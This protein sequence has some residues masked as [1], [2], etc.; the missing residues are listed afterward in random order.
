ML[1]VRPVAVMCACVA[2]A[3]CGQT[4][5]SQVPGTAPSAFQVTPAEIDLSPSAPADTFNGQDDVAGVS[6][7]PLASPECTGANGSIVVGGNGV[8]Q[9]DVAG[10]ALLFTVV[11]AG[12][13]PPAQC[14]ITVL[15]SDG[16]YGV[17][18]ANYSNVPVS[19]I[20]AAERRIIASP[21]SSSSTLTFTS[22]ASPQNIDVSGFTG[23]TAATVSCKSTGSGV[24]VTPAQVSG[25][26]TFAVIPFGQGAISNSCG[27][28]IADQS[29]HHVTVTATLSISAVAKFTAT[30]DK[31]QFGCAGTAAPL[32]CRTLTPIALSEPGTPAFSI[33]TRPTLKGSCAN[34]FYGPLAM[35][36]GPAATLF[37]GLLPV[38]TLACSAV[39]VTDGSTPAQ[40]VRIAIAPA[41]A[42]APAG[43]AAATAP[44]CTGS[45]ARVAAPR[46][47][48][49]MYVWNPYKVDGGVYESYLES[50]VI[51]KD[52]ALCGVS[53]LVSW[54]EIEKTKG[55]YTWGTIASQAAPYVN[56]G[57]T[58]NLLIADASEV[59]SNTA[60]PAWVTDP[61]AQDGDGVASISCSGQPPYPDYLDPTFEADYESL[62][63]NVVAHYANDPTIG[64][65]RFGI[66]AGVEAYA[67]H[68]SDYP[69]DPC[70]L[71]WEAQGYSFSAWVDHTR[72]IVTHMGSLNSSKQLM[73]ALNYIPGWSDTLY[74]YPNAAAEDAA[75]HGIG[76]GTE[77]LG[78]GHV[79]DPGTTPAACNP[80][81]TNASIYWCQAFTR[82]AGVVPFEFQPIE[83][84]SAPV[85]TYNIDFANLLQ[86]ALDNN[87]QLFEI[88][89][90]DW[91]QADSPSSPVF[92]AGHR[93]EWKAALQSTALIVG[94]HGQ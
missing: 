40:R 41:I 3:A 49:G 21:Q 4:A 62:I 25:G 45:D 20:P 74:D 26:G 48:H 50:D 59:G 79:A 52:P 77:N 12:A 17:V 28:A 72:R 86:Y 84:V 31:A 56:A 71:A 8:A 63:D 53:L 2:L 67:A 81:A 35:N 33:V 60:T 39:V 51:G 36:G 70:S 73:I 92:V 64:Y 61:F 29:K 18:A 11:A 42:A 90:Q 9:R 88:Y 55:T 16:S 58:V 5:G 83:A 76:F 54:S 47:P 69:S 19:E 7:T 68:L 1:G 32:N 6:Y 85:S 15:G 23:P 46:A 37:A 57:L 30:P 38:A 14:T 78:I 75:N 44:P 65:I 89:P 80:Q 91:L 43:L 22:L 93:A 94:A 34:A 27:I 82:H 87:T 66:G 13:A 10:A 24:Q